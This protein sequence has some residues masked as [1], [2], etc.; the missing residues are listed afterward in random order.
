MTFYVS[1]NLTKWE[2]NAIF[3]MPIADSSQQ[4]PESNFFFSYSLLSSI[5]LLLCYVLRELLLLFCF[6]T[7][8]RKKFFFNEKCIFWYL[9]LFCSYTRDALKIMPLILLCWYLMSEAHVG[10]MAV[11]GKS[12]FQYSITLWCYVI[13]DSRGAVWQRDIRFGSAYDAKGHMEL[14]SSMH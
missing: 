1:A 8:D 14:N 4:S 12:S 2:K 10:D 13:D 5:L 6:L 11:E 7:W 9:V 3:W